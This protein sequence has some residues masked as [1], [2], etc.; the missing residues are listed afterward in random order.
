MKKLCLLIACLALVLSGCCEKGI[1]EG[2]VYDKKHNAE[3]TNVMMIPLCISNGK[4]MTCSPIP[5]IVHHHENWEVNIKSYNEKEKKYETAIYYVNKEVYDRVK[6]GDMFKYDSNT[7][8]DEEPITK[9][10][11][12]N[13][14]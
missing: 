14:D 12:A 1:T 3:Y 13:A 9:E 2:E 4:S 10:R 7:M 11:R 5:Y 6:I 8:L